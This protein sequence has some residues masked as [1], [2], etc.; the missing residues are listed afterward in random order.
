MSATVSA[1]I[2]VR[3]SPSQPI[4]P[5]RNGDRLTRAEFERRYEAMPHLKKAELI[6]GV[7]YVPFPVRHR[8]HGRQH[9]HLDV[10]FISS[11]PVES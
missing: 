6:Q 9:V 2:P 1:P 11:S 4:P 10:H 8:Y 5:L 3:S 7:V